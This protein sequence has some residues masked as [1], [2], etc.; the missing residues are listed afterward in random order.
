ML[1]RIARE[2]AAAD[3]WISFARYMDLCLHAE[4]GYY[5]GEAPKFGAGGDF[6]TA[7]EMGKLFGRTLARQ[8]AQ[9]LARHRSVLEIGAGTGALA[10]AILETIDCDYAI[11]ETSAALAARQRERLGNR[12]R[13]LQRLPE[14]FSGVVIANEVVD[15]MPVHAVA[16]RDS[17]IFERGVVFQSGSLAWGERPAEGTLREEASK[18]ELSPPYESEIGLAARAWMR[19]LG[20]ILDEGIILVIDYGFPA[21]EYY[22]P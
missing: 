15:A 16:W 12:V 18:I 7:P 20:A 6:V 11:L 9:A 2:I 13:W 8:V 3:G 17:G 5:A 4:G 14:H 19:S 10:E 1:E 21:R 22:H